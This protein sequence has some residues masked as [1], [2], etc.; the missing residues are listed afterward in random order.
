MPYIVNAVVQTPDTLQSVCATLRIASQISLWMASAEDD[1]ALNQSKEYHGE[2][3]AYIH[4]ETR[5][6]SHLDMV[7]CA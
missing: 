2:V 1:H 7:L 3:I 4:Q 5:K 6:T